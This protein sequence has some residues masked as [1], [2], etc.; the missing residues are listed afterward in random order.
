MLTTAE[1]CRRFQVSRRTVTN[2]VKQGLACTHAPPAGGGRPQNLF[3]AADIESYLSREVQTGR[4]TLRKS[5]APPPP[6]AATLPRGKQS[7]HDVELPGLIPGAAQSDA[8]KAGQDLPAIL[9]RLRLAEKMTYSQW[10]AAVTANQKEL[11]ARRPAP[12]SAAALAD[13]QDGWKN[14]VEARRKFEKDL[15]GLM[16]DHERYVDIGSVCDVVARCYAA[17]NSDLDQIG[18]SIAETCVGK[19]ANEIRVIVD[20]AVKRAKE[21]IR[22][23]WEKL[24][25]QA[26]EMA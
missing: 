10:V 15:P 18:I 23:G 3:K 20:D 19:S 1:V 12:F 6:V 24:A 4:S 13:L 17:T 9:A 8:P 25:A 2:W 5:Q 16:R 22:A 14:M 26:E 21:H 7:L 11:K